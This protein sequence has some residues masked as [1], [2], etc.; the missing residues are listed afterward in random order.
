MP[1]ISSPSSHAPAATL[2]RR[3]RHRLPI[4]I[5]CLLLLWQTSLAFASGGSSKKPPA[6]PPT[7]SSAKTVEAPDIPPFDPSTLESISPPLEAI[8]LVPGWNFV[9]IPEQ[10][11]DTSAAAVLAPIEGKYFKVWAVDNCDTEDPWKLYQ[12]SDLASSDLETIDPTKGMWLKS[13]EV[14]DLPSTG[15]LAPSTKIRLCPGWNLIGFPAAQIRPMPEAMKPFEGSY[16][17]VMTY[18]AT[19]TESQWDVYST[20]VPEWGNDLWEMKPGRAYWVLATEEVTAEILNEGPPPEVELLT[21]DDLTVITEP[22]E[23]LGAVRSPFLDHWT[24]R[25]RPVGETEWTDFATGNRTTEGGPLDDFDPTLLLNGLY[26]L[27]LVAVDWAGQTA[28]SE[29]RSAL[30]EGGM[31]IGNFTLSFLDFTIPLAGLD[32]QISRTYDSRD[33]RVTR[34]FG[35]G[36]SLGLRRGSYRN[37]RLPGEG[38]QIE[39]GFLPCEVPREQLS[40]VTVIALSEREIYRFRPRLV[41]LASTL[42][43]CTARVGFEL[44]AGARPGTTLEIL[45]N[46]RVF[47]ANASDR[48]VDLESNE[49]FEPQAVRLTTAD[50]RA[51]DLDLEDGV[52]G[53]ATPDGVSLTLDEDGITHSSGLAVKFE[54]DAEGRISRIVDPAGNAVI[55]S[56]TPEGDLWRVY[57]QE[58]FLTWFTYY[59]EHLLEK[60]HDPTGLEA[61][62]ASYDEDGR[63]IKTCQGVVTCSQIEHDLEGREEVRIDATGRALTWRYDARGNVLSVTDALGNTTHFEYDGDRLVLQRDALGGETIYSYSAD[64]YLESRTVPVP[65]GADPAAYTTRFTHDAHGR[66]T[67][68]T[69]PTGAVIHYDVDAAGRQTATRDAAGT[70]LESRVYGPGGVVVEESDL[71]G[72]VKY[73][74]LTPGGNPRRSVDSVFDEVTTATYDPLEQLL[75]LDDGKTDDGGVVS[76]FTYDR[77]GRELR[78]E[79]GDGSWSEKVY[80]HYDVWTEMRGPDGTLKRRFAHRTGQLAGWDLENGASIDYGYDQAGRLE[81][82]VDVDG[83]ITRIEHDEVGRPKKVVAP[84]GGVTESTFDALGRV[85]EVRDAEGHRT[86]RTYTADGRVATR[87]DARGHTWSTRYGRN[88]VEL[89]DPL[90]RVSRTELTAHGD[91]WKV[92]L[93]DG[94]SV[95][96]EFLSPSLP[97]EEDALPT[98][99]RDEAGRERRFGYNSLA[100]LETVTD[101]GG[102]DPD[103][104]AHKLEWEGPDLRALRAPTGEAVLQYT[105][106]ALDRVKTKTYGDGGTY[107]FDHDEV[108]RLAKMTIPSGKTVEK[109]YDEVGR[110]ATSS[111]SFGDHVALTWTIRDQVHTVTDATGTTTRHYDTMGELAAVE[112]STG[113]RV[114]YGRDLLGR[115]TSV[116][117]R[118]AT[119][120]P[121]QTTT[122]TRDPV[123]N[124]RQI[125]DPLGGVTTFEWDLVNRLSRRVLPNGVVSEWTYNDRDQVRSVTHRD[126]NGEILASRA[127]TREATGEPSRIEHE[128]GSALEVDYDAGLRVEKERFLAADGTPLDTRVYGYD[129]AGSRRSVTTSTRTETYLYQGGMRLTQVT[130]GPSR[131]RYTYDLDGQVSFLERDGESWSL[132]YDLDG[133]LREIRNAWTG[134]NVAGYTYDGLGRRVELRDDG[135][136]RRLVNVP[137]LGDGLESPHLVVDD[138]G[139]L[140][141]SYVYAGE[142]PLLRLGPDG[143][144]YYLSDAM[145]SVIALADAD[146]AATAKFAYDS[147]GNPAP[148]SAPPEDLAIATGGDFRFHGAWRD[149]A[150]G[151]YDL[152]ARTYDPRTGRFL[153][154]DPA[155]PELMMPESWHPYQFAFANPHVYRD[156]TGLFS[157]MSVNVAMSVRGVMQGARAFVSRMIMNE[158]RETTAEFAVNTL[159]KVLTA[160]AP[161]TGDDFFKIAQ[162]G[163]DFKEWEQFETGVMNFLCQIFNVQAQ[164]MRFEPI[165]Q[166]WSG[167]PVGNGFSCF[168]ERDPDDIRDRFKKGHREPDFVIHPAGMLAGA[169]DASGKKKPIPNALL[170]GEIKASVSTF[171]R[172]YIKPGMRGGQL[173]AI[174]RYSV[175][176]AEPG[177]FSLLVA[178]KDG[179]KPKKQMILFKANQ[180]ARDARI[181]SPRVVLVAIQ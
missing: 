51:F 98:R 46:D 127:Y 157:V 144:I 151:L 33:R 173:E 156:P 90:G 64:G 168:E 82:I 179:S 162:L 128:D 166:E 16:R 22:T 132:A 45:G 61:L 97:G 155:E 105:Y 86:A 2:R 164:W 170:V 149:A 146:G 176:H 19:A 171:Y 27:Q 58:G 113:W 66:L 104:A 114:D 5:L 28:E 79:H 48:L 74:D 52:T 8:T 69:L 119:D 53:L 134:K 54:R 99:V 26:E 141:A 76:T 70:V 163:D 31:K 153:T 165:I 56:Y 35:Y 115:V 118:A 12:P 154:R 142:T 139:A 85:I 29:I 63:L 1:T 21:P 83:G 181:R 133:H 147:F 120:A 130:G 121:A 177:Q 81:R 102:A 100:Q 96:A 158:V 107:V 72:T 73:E 47:H 129:T 67:S 106:D 110:L 137:V 44:V 15:V 17:R 112:H 24:L 138:T 62:A 3:D 68:V 143:P 9:S 39:N 34:D 145:G 116:S 77:R 11:D 140:L 92:V 36:W 117:V 172:T 42:G 71:F 174:V 101:L 80:G 124:I 41:D 6:M 78:T 103:R 88:H 160:M 59:P 84:N 167:D 93:P 60:I 18:D 50:G 161:M 91:P 135:G 37:N 94:R 43:G 95:E 126:P 7:E 13:L 111:T 55:Y 40:H 148:G 159:V 65:E 131:E 123:G 14:V 10:P 180:I 49:I 108:G 25:H 87:T 38:W 152:R 30:V 4:Q 20:D 75:T 109:T 89:E 150:T 175:M 57:D 178:L 136:A 169:P 23:V 125:T 32:L 122:Y